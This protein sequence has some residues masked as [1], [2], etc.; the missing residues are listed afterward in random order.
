MCTLGE[1]ANFI[2]ERIRTD[3]LSSTNYISTENMNSNFGGITPAVSIPDSTNVIRYRK[4]DILL[5]NI[6]PYLRKVWAASNDGGCSAD[7]FVFRANKLSSSFLYYV[8][9]NDTFINY[10]MAG[11]KGVKMPRGDKE[12]MLKYNFSIPKKEEQ[13]KISSLLF[14]LDQRIAT[15]NKIIEDLK[16][17]KSAIVE[18]EYSSKF[19]NNLHIGNFIEQISTRNKDNAVQNVLSVSNRQGFIYVKIIVM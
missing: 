8:M 19:T 9:A 2:K 11:T 12:Q 13:D 15:Q 6:R 18:M 17:L 4:G 3:E 14:L 16:K 5:S 7:I 10:V 1:V